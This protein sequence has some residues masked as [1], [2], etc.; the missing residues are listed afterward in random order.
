MKYY[1]S[2]LLLVFT[3]FVLISCDSGLKFENPNDPNN[4]TSKSETG[5]LGGECYGNKTCDEGLTCDEASNT[6]VQENESGDGNDTGTDTAPVDD[7]C[8]ATEGLA[9]TT[10]EECGPCMICITGGRCAKGCTKDNDCTLTGTQ[11]NTKLARC[12]NTYASNKACSETNCPSGCCYAEKGLTGL[13]CATSTNA[14]PL[15][16]GLCPQHQIY[17]S[18]NSK[19]VDAACSSTTDNCSAI[20]SDSINP[21]AKC[22]ECQPGELICK[23]KT[24]TSGCSAGSLIN[25]MECTPSGK[26]CIDGISICCSGT[27]CIQGF[28]Y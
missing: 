28:C 12:L 2:I 8:A 5:E 10:D 16:C 25:M 1:L 4:K 3:A 14:T 9:C 17:S 15:I 24:S 19:C 22:Y 13:K 7:S 6:C 11:C 27:P 20:N 21:P 23:A 18:E 26:H